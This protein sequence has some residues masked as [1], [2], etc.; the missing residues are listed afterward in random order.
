MS[1]PI[2][3]A[4]AQAT[5]YRH[6]RTAV[7]EALRRRRDRLLR[8][9]SDDEGLASDVLAV[10]IAVVADSLSRR[11][12][13]AVRTFVLAALFDLRFFFVSELPAIVSVAL[14]VVLTELGGRLS[15]RRPDA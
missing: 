1:S 10:C 4:R 14:V 12:V 15:R 2:P 6:A 8:R 13:A 7:E 3:T 11:G 9:R 5:G